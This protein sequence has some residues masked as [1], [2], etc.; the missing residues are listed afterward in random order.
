M[1]YYTGIGSRETP[2][3]ILQ[4]MIESAKILSTKGYCLRSGGADGADSAFE[5]GATEKEIY[6]PWK[7]FNGSD[8]ELHKVC[9][10]AIATAESIHPAWDKL[11]QGAQKLHARNCYQILGQRLTS[12]SEFVI[13]WTKDGKEI[14]GTRTAIVLAKKYNIPVFNLGIKSVEE[15][16]IKRIDEE[17]A[18]DK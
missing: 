2:L 18:L 9:S 13:C 17:Y 8:S 16:F 1:K 5:K 11:S 15:A 4:I 7:G 12:P 14:G 10:R 3:E 6:L